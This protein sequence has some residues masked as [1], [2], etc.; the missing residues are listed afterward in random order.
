MNLRISSACDG[1]N[2]KYKSAVHIGCKEGRIRMISTNFVW[3]FAQARTAVEKIR[4]IEW[5][6]LQNMF[7]Y[8]MGMGAR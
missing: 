8:E 3:P 7:I 1:I 2:A 4:Y 5:V 6:G